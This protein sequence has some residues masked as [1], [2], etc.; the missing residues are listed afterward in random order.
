[1]CF[2][3]KGEIKRLLKR[4]PVGDHNLLKSQEG[5][6]L[7]FL[8]GVAE[9]GHDGGLEVD[10]LE[11]KLALRVL[12]DD[13]S[14]V[15]ASNGENDGLG[16]GD[17][18]GSEDG[19]ELVEGSIVVLVEAVDVG[20]PEALRAVDGRAPV[21][22]LTEKLVFV[23]IEGGECVNLAFKEVGELGEIR[24]NVLVSPSLL[25][26]EVKAAHNVY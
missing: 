3:G 6:L 1:M 10:L 12:T 25:K 8:V 23:D 20:S 19:T 26:E 7:D 14:D 22:S 2:A 13:L 18:L 17:I 9:V 4:L 15:P 16:G 21:E 24:I 11:N 5:L